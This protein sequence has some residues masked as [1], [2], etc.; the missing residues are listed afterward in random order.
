MPRRSTIL[1]PRSYSLELLGGSQ[2][3]LHQ[4][5]PVDRLGEYESHAVPVERRIQP[6][7]SSVVVRTQQHKVAKAVFA[8]SPEPPYMVRL[9]QIGLE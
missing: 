9:A 3:V 7:Y 2:F 8:A 1:L 4:F 5:K 6:M